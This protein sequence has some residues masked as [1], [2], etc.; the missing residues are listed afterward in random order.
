[1]KKKNDPRINAG[2]AFIKEYFLIFLA[3]SAFNGFHMWLYQEFQIHGLLETN[4]QLAINIL[5]GYVAFGAACVTGLVAGIRHISWN[6]PMRKLSEA[7]RKITHGDFSV[8]IAPLRKDGRKDYV[9]VM[10]DDFNTMA[11]E[12]QSIETLKTDFTANVSHEIK[13]PLAVIQSYATAL[14]NDDLNTDERRDYC[15]T[16]VEASQKLSTLVSNILKLNKLENQG[17]M[18][19]AR[20]FNLDEQIRRCAVAF[21]EMWE[22]KNINFNAELEEI[23]VCYDENT[24]EIVWNNL[25]SNAIKFTGPCGTISIQLKAKDGYA[26]ASIT[27]TG[28]GMDEDT[29]KRVFDKFYQGDTS[30]AQEGNGLGLALV[31]QIVALFGGTVTVE[32]RPGQGST[33]TVC[34]KIPSA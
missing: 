23:T 27:D 12:L 15:K 20:P 19:G 31:R 34:L 30:H 29:Q 28:C 32:S 10:F 8:R 13:T 17:I 7:A 22:S 24:L 1:M 25:I 5:I 16:I 3:L 4:V 6:R 14:Q 9:E 18:P 21:E 11:R 33:F 2:N 26:Y